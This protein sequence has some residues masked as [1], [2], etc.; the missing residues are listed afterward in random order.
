MAVSAVGAPAWPGCPSLPSW[1]GVCTPGCGAGAA[2][3]LQRPDSPG[4]GSRAAAPVPVRESGKGHRRLPTL[5]RPIAFL[6][7]AAPLDRPSTRQWLLQQPGML[8]TPCRRGGQMKLTPFSARG[9]IPGS[10]SGWFLISGLALKPA[11]WER[12]KT[13][14][15][16]EDRLRPYRGEV[17]FFHSCL[18][19]ME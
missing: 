11:Q 2:R 10:P 1:D 18:L 19:R 16:P 13:S 14:L 15:C 4:A 8:R 6:T 9:A 12:G 5:P 17:G 3:G 7:R